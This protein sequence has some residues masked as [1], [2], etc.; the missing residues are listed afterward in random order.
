MADKVVGER[1]INLHFYEP[2]CIS[3]EEYEEIRNDVL[4]NLVADSGRASTRVLFRLLALNEHAY[5][6]AKR[7]NDFLRS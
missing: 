1:V 5:L 6:E 2:C 4:A 3:V 7:H